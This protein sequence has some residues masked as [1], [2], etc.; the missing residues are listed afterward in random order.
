MGTVSITDLR[1][2]EAKFDTLVA[3]EQATQLELYNKQE[4]LKQLAGPQ[5]IVDDYHSAAIGLPPIRQADLAEWLSRLNQ[6]NP[7]IQQAAK[8]VESAQLEV[9][10]AQA[11]RYPTLDFTNSLQRNINTQE[12]A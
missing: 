4:L 2:A 9:K 5:A 7:K 10:K 1:E 8:N 3:Q 6:V 12:A 11:A